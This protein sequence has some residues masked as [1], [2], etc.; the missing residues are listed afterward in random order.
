[1]NKNLDSTLEVIEKLS[2]L[3]AKNV[4][5]LDEASL[6]TGLKKSYLYKLTHFKE[7][8]HYKPNGGMIY[9]DRADLEAWM[10]QNRVATAK[11]I[12]QKA[13]SYVV[14]GQKGGRR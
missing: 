12:D 3:G 6:I 9:F 7:I 4:F 13:N 1:M 2:L 5:T 8:P 14:T 10:K 11:E